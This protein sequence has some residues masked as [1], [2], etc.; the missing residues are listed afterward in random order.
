MILSGFYLEDVYNLVD[1]FCL[2][3]NKEVDPKKDKVLNCDFCKF[4][5][6]PSG[7]KKHIPNCVR[8]P[9]DV[10]DTAVILYNWHNLSKHLKNYTIV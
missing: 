1:L 6:L 7:F 2:R 3:T 10:V 5:Y 4:N 8:A 9:K